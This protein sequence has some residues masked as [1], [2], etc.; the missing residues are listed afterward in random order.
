MVRPRR[1]APRP[2]SRPTRNSESELRRSDAWCSFVVPQEPAGKAFGKEVHER[3]R[4]TA[5]EALSPAKYR[6]QPLAREEV[7]FVGETSGRDGII[8]AFAVGGVSS[9]AVYLANALSPK[10]RGGLGISGKA[11]LVVT[12]TAGAFFLKS[13]LTVAEARADPDKFFGNRQSRAAA[14]PR[15]QHQLAL[16]QSAS[17][18]VYENPFKVIFSIALPIYGLLFYKESTNPATA[19]MPLSQRLIHT[20]VYGQ[21][22]AVLS[23]VG[24]MAFVK[25]MDTEGPYRIENGRVTRGSSMRNQASQYYTQVDHMPPKPKT[26]AR[27]GAQ[28][29]DGP[30]EPPTGAAAAEARAA[31]AES[32]RL[33]AERQ[34]AEEE[35]RRGGDGYGLLVPLLYAPVVPLMRVGLRGRVSPE[36]LTQLTLGVIGVALAHAGSYMFTDSTVAARR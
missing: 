18:F 21:M 8:A 27:A 29:A 14:A 9:G 26:K 2:A 13:H 35:A 31:A 30:P 34:A 25:T 22:V 7:A 16:W 33:A 11:A 5:Q 4:A 20:R 19:S 28:A 10:F 12:P 17:N 23:T 32:Q 3:P 15:A 1:C 36:R 24:V 6:S